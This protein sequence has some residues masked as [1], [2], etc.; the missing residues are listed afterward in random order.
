M[1]SSS[2]LKNKQHN[3]KKLSISLIVSSILIP[4]KKGTN[5]GRNAE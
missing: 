2:Y 1:T 5:E 3:T 4:K